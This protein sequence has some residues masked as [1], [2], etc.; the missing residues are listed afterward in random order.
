MKAKSAKLLSLILALM[1]AFSMAACG[2]NKGGNNGGSGNEEETFDLEAYKATSTS[3]YDSQLGEFKAAY[4]AAKEEKNDSKRYALMAMAEAKLM[5]SGVML[6]TNTRGGNFAITRVAPYTVDYT[7]WGTDNDRLHNAVIVSGAPL[8]SEEVAYL[9]AKYDELKGTGTYED[10]AKAYLAANGHTFTDQYNYAYSSDP[11]T[12]DA[13]ATS[14]AADSEAIVNT[15][16]GLLEYDNEGI[17]Q[18]ALAESYTVSDD[19]TEYTF[20]IRDGVKWV[21]S[22][23]QELG[24]VTADDFVAAFQHVLDADGGLNWLVEPVI[25][26]VSEYLESA[27]KDFSV[28][29]VKANMEENTVTYTLTDAISYFPT[30]LG[31]NI[32]A[33]MNRA[34][35]E[36][37]GGKFG[38][39]YNASADDYDYGN[40]PENIAYCGPY[41][42]TQNDSESII[43]FQAWEGYWNYDNL[44]VKT[45]TWKFNDGKDPTKAYNDM[46]NETLTGAGL[47][48]SSLELAKTE[49]VGDTDKTWF[50]T[51]A[52]VSNTEA[53][54][55][56]AFFN[57]NRMA[58]SNFNDGAVKTPM[59][60]TAQ[61]N[62]NLAMKNVHFR[63][64]IMFS[65][66]RASYNAQSTGDELKYNSLRN[67]YTPGN[68]VY[69]S[70]PVTVMM[71]G[72]EK[73]YPANTA[74]GQIMQDQIDADGVPIT[75]WTNDNVF[76]SYSSD[77]FDGW[78]DKDNA[79]AEMQTA[80]AELEAAFTAAGYAF[81]KDDKGNV[82]K[83]YLASDTKKNAVLIQLDLPTYTAS[84]TYYNRA[85]SFKKSI[86]STLGNF[87]QVNLTGA[88]S[89]AQWYYAGYYTDYGYQANYS[90][91]DVSGWGPDYG[92]PSTYLDTFLGGGAGYMVK[93]IGIW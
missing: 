57:I 59:N 60:A 55:F 54:S 11:Q 28:V 93:C 7:L 15:Y 40:K 32:F 52:Y 19:G 89:S 43:K 87:V 90:I 16:D 69:T 3:L 26:G 88:A 1:L 9:R 65:V 61:A 44:N 79:K 80:F 50:E 68:F 45:I 77:G 21:N 17:Q 56:T 49:K 91:Y 64:A 42:V 10:T 34:F 23:G 66:D 20:K 74:Y 53:T 8:T 41:L 82:T 5:E 38:T 33:P 71:N 37:K 86:E 6:P 72:V 47:N 39:E 13:L 48:A 78:Y 67:S 31:Y 62:S 92:D 84:T 51:Y 30:M 73:N 85:M 14:R 2:G 76:G 12:W 83:M 24:E 46:K 70:E 63:R 25:A 58:Y 18:P 75:V 4:A 27:T 22:Q 35:Y 36:S 29:G 81:E